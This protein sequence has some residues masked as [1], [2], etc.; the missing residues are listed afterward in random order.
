MKQPWNLLVGSKY[1]PSHS[2]DFF[3]DGRDFQLVRSYV[4][5]GGE[6]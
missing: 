3:F 1:V 4:C 5:C 6:Q 2:T